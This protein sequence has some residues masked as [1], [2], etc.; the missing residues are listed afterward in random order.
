MTGKMDKEA[1]ENLFRKEF[2]DFRESLERDFRKDIRELRKSVETTNVTCHNISTRLEEV[3]QENEKLKKDN[4]IL[5]K[6]CN[7]LAARVQFHE[8]G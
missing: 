8:G 4:D 3:L 7:D 2:K 6:R 1:Y 5:K